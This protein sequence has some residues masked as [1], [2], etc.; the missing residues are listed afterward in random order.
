MAP[1]QVGRQLAAQQ[2]GVAP[3]EQQPESLPLQPI[4]EQLPTRQVLDFIQQQMAWIAVYRVDRGDE[5]VVVGHANQPLVV[6]VEIPTR[7]Y[8]SQQVHCQK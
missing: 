7:L 5:A 1:G 2:V 4:H 3:G 8:L 6:E